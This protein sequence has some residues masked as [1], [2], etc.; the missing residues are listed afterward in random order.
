M[1]MGIELELFTTLEAG[2]AHEVAAVDRESRTRDER[3]LLGSEKGDRLGDFVWLAES[4]HG[5][6]ALDL[7]DVLISARS[8]RQA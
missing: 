6:H 5:V 8:F 1:A 3:R 7:L 4:A 2:S